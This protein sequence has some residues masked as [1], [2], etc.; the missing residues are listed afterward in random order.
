MHTVVQKSHCKPFPKVA[1]YDDTCS[2]PKRLTDTDDLASLPPARIYSPQA[3]P[4]SEDPG[5]GTASNPDECE[6]PVQAVERV[7]TD[8]CPGSGGKPVSKWG[9]CGGKDYSGPTCCFGYSVCVEK[10]EFYSLCEGANVPSELIPWHSQCGGAN[11]G[12]C[13]PGSTCEE[14]DGTA[15]CKPELRHIPHSGSS[16]RAGVSNSAAIGVAIAVLAA[17]ALLTVGAFGALSASTS[18]QPRGRWKLH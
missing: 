2:P 16:T 12:T 10:S 4:T 6:H 3:S 13:E 11:T 7:Y 1:I 14:I 5:F 15:Y 9:Q 8:T 18:N 17:L